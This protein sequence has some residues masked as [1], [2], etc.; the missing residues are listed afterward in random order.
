MPI[1]L[2]E[3]CSN[4]PRVSLQ[5]NNPLEFSLPENMILDYIWNETDV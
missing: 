2:S 4:C 5:D 3:E 1:S